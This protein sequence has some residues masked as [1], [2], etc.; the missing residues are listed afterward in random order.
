MELTN[1]WWLLI[2]IFVGGSIM[3]MGVSKK[4]EIILG[5]SV[6]R[7]KYAPAMLLILPYIVWAG[8]RGNFIDTN[9]YRKMFLDAPSSFNSIYS[10]IINRKGD[11]GFS[12]FVVILKSIIGNQDI[13]FFLIISLIQA[14]CIMYIFRKYSSNYWISLFLFITSAGYLSWMFNGIRQFLAVCICFMCT[15]L[16]LRKRYIPLTVLILIASSIHGTAILMIP[17]IFISYGESW[18]K[19]TIILILLSLMAVVFVDSFTN[20]IELATN[21][22]QYE[23]TVKNEIWLNDNGT[24]PLRVL[25]ASVPT[26]LAFIWRNRIREINNDLINLCVN[27]SIISTSIYIISMFTSGVLIGRLPIYTLLYSYIL[28]PWELDNLFS[29]EIRRII[30]FAM[31]LLYIIY[32]YYQM[33]FIW[34]LI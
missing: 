22:T 6:Y 5:E 21:G 13:L 26:I 28:L 33:H 10:Y 32:F 9:A 20:I 25:V 14:I 30:M 16:I 8:Y 29:K 27:M 19:K 15:G 3:T 2:W 1:Y 23:G 24:N 18:N 11:Y 34:G 31:I 12:V 17:F 7:W 4:Q